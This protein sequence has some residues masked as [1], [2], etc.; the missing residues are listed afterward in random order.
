[1]ADV[2]VPP[3]IFDL[4][5][6]D[7][8]E[9]FDGPEYPCGHPGPYVRVGGVQIGQTYTHSSDMAG[10]SKLVGASQLA[11][12]HNILHFDLPVLGVDMLAKTRKREVYDT[13]VVEAVLDPPENDERSG[14]TERAMKRY[15]LQATC[16]RHGLVGKEQKIKDLV[17]EFGSW[18]AIPV[19]HP[20]FLDYLEGDVK[21]TKRLFA[22][23]VSHDIPEYAWREHRVQALAS[24][25]TSAGLEVDRPLL[26]ERHTAVQEAK[27]E[28]TERL[29]TKYEIPTT[30]AS[31]KP[32]K[33]PH[34]TKDGKAAIAKAFL[35]LG[36]D[37]SDLPRTTPS[38]THPAGQHA[39]GGDAM[40]ELAAKH[41]DSADIQD[42]CDV[43][44]ALA[45][46]RSVYGTA[47]TYLRGDG[48]VHPSVATFQASG[49][50]SVTKPGMTVYGKRDGRVVERAIFQASEGHLLLTADLAQIDM[51]AVAAHSQDE[52]YIDVFRSK[53][54]LHSEIAS[55]LWG[56]PKVGNPKREIAKPMGHGSNYGMQ[57]EKI[58]ATAGIPI[59]EAEQFLRIRAAMFPQL[60]RWTEQ[61]RQQAQYGSLD[62]GFGRIMRCNP[63]RAFTQGPALMGQ[64]TTRDL[65]ME[66]LLR[67]PDDIA[68]MLRIMV[69]DEVVLEVPI[70]DVEEVGQEII[71]A[72]TFEWAPPW[73]SIP[74]PIE[75]DLG[76]SGKSWMDCYRKD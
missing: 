55:T 18:C 61:I 34:T 17:K 22:H 50:W 25:T 12:G 20:D 53:R 27:A 67:L 68:R 65:M 60:T 11:V 30:T 15:G 43:V 4:E 51:R 69:H 62:N 38:A 37:E 71:K 33:S 49:R 29:V 21:A 36:V 31:G 3:L 70:A 72:M 64:G 76:K 19:D 52:N 44:A 74:V 14:A 39:F 47:V 46:Q 35:S 2:T 56:G 9:R 66:C 7:G 28:L 54:D 48:R 1:M 59:H 13:M 42:L 24:T 41:H 10:L 57:A 23:Q 16:E 63:R 75:V 26:M 5:T 40:E 73:A 8:N 32:A 6:H 58:A 45:G